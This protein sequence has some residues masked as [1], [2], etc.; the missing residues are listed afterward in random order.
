[1]T[2]IRWRSFWQDSAAYSR[3]K[4]EFSLRQAN[5]ARTGLQ[6]FDGRVVPWQV[7]ARPRGKPARCN[8]PSGLVSAEQLR[9]CC[10][11]DGVILKPTSAAMQ[12]FTQLPAAD[13]RRQ[14]YF[15]NLLQQLA[16]DP[17]ATDHFG[18]LAQLDSTAARSVLQGMA[19]SEDRRTALIAQLSSH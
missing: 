7:R 10:G 17:Q 16:W 9:R 3:F 4:G 8:R 1:M 13:A 12:W 5:A 11:V 15:S 2:Q 19:L 18:Q 14:P 6:W